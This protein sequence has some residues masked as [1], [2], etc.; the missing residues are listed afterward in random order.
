MGSVE[1]GFDRG[2]RRGHRS[3]REFGDETRE[4]RIGAGLSQTALGRAVH[5][6]AAKI[7]RLERA[8]L[9]GL[10][11]MDASRVASVLGLEL[12]VRAYPAGAPLR[13][14]AQAERLRRVLSH[15]RPPLRCRLDVPLPQRPDQPT[16]LRG[17]DALLVGHGK[18]TAIEL[19]TRLR[20][21]QATIRRHGMKRRDDPV[22]G[23][24]L[25]L[26][27]TRTNRRIYAE[28]A[29]LWPDLPRLRTSRVLAA[30]E[31]G[32]HPPSGILLI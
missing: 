5:M 15:V 22:E 6:S 18:R 2:T 8:Q 17:W 28:N 26:A 24:L 30:L 29:D 3:L 20:D 23:F 32:D 14:A 11:I 1:R 19:E 9:P 16:E 27:D 4:A 21:V 7:S 25:V 12:V 31:A 10:T 13:D